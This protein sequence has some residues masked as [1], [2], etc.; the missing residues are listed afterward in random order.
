MSGEKFK[1]ITMADRRMI[2]EGLRKHMS[3]GN[4]SK[5]LGKTWNAIAYEIKSSRVSESTHYRE[6]CLRPF[7]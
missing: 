6:P 5:M 4:I 1:R 2:E 3:I 7:A